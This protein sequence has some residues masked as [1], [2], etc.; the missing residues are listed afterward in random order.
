MPEF[1]PEMTL[2]L[3]V[4]DFKKSVAWY[5]DVLG[6][7]P[8]YVIDEMPWGEF[9]SPVGG[10]TFGLGQAQ[11][12][13]AVP[14]GGG[15]VIGL[16]VADIVA[17]RSELEAKGVK[18]DGPNDELPGLVI[19]ATFRDPDGNGFMLAQSLGQPG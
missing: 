6:C 4:S 9:T 2:A 13:E 1:K 16:N 17:A 5:Q 14:Q 12:G 7:T 15:A 10:V 3:T 11:A 18:F 19:L 8:V